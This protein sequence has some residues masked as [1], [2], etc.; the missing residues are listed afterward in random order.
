MPSATAR[1]ATVVRRLRRGCYRVTLDHDH[2][3]QITKEANGLWLAQIRATESGNLIRYA[4]LW[5]TRR[6]AVEELVS[7]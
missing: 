5:E 2:F 3:G 1:P 7:L 4:G 6:A